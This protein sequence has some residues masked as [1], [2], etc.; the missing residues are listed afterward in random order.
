MPAAT[1]GRGAVPQVAA[2]ALR[3]SARRSAAGLPRPARPLPVGAVAGL[4]R[5]RR[6][7]R[8]RGQPVRDVPAA[9]P[10]PPCA[11][12]R[13]EHAGAATAPNPA[14]LPY[15]QAAPQARTAA[16]N[17]SKN[18]LRRLPVGV[19]SAA[20]F[21]GE[22]HRPYDFGSPRPAHD[23]DRCQSQ[24]QLRPGHR[25]LRRQDRQVPRRQPGRGARPRHDGGVR[26][27]AGG[28]PARRRRW[29][30]PTWRSSAMCTRTTWPACT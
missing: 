4:P 28:Q 19:R 30:R 10:E 22:A 16:R 17:E 14:A 8:G 5:R 12:D 15:V 1:P 23:L 3:R 11:A 2:F 7:L 25:V 24:R 26:H 20:G 13:P 27:A 18:L 6:P 9:L 21:I 29:P